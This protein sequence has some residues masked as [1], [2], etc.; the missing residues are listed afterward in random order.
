MSSRMD[1]GTLFSCSFVNDGPD[2]YNFS[3]PDGGRTTPSVIAYKDSDVLIGESAVCELIG[4]L[5]NVIQNS[6]RFIG[7]SFCDPQVQRKELKL[8]QQCRRC[9]K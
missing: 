1:V 7:K 6:K 2:F 4:N 8:K 9:Q 5:Q 3:N